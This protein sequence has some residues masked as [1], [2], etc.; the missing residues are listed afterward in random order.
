MK[1]A[2]HEPCEVAAIVHEKPLA[3]EYDEVLFGSDRANTLWVKFSDQHGITEWIGKFG[4]GC[5]SSARVDKVIDP[6]K[7][8]ISAGGFGYLIDATTRK[9]LNH[10]CE[11]YTQ[12]VAYDAQSN[13]FIVAD[14]VRIRL[15]SSGEV[16]FAS[17]RIALDGIRDLKIK[18]RKVHGLA[19]TGFEREE[20]SFT[21]D[22]DTREVD[23]PVD[24]SSWDKPP[25]IPQADSDPVSKPWWKFW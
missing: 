14:Y 18:G 11:E 23:C 8:L 13:C 9:L 17:T 24:Y 6:D 12:D 10:H 7:F 4:A 3:G 19:S 15:I 5:S 1:A 2:S 25:P 22:L 20:S 16:V 21:F